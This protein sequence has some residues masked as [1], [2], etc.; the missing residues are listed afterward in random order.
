MFYSNNY[1][2][3]PIKHE[4]HKKE[5]EEIFNKK[6]TRKTCLRNYQS[7]N[8]RNNKEYGLSL[9]KAQRTVEKTIAQ[10]KLWARKC[11][12][13]NHPRKVSME[14]VSAHLLVVAKMDVEVEPG[15]GCNCE[16][17]D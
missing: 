4:T 10:K 7:S 6:D 1:M 16:V 12:V 9:P 2:N 15:N 13:G 11:K 17:Q 14:Q 8:N 3:H 5:K